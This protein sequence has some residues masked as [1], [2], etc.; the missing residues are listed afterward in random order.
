[1]TDASNVEW[2]DLFAKVRDLHQPRY[3]RDAHG[4]KV[5]TCV[6]DRQAWPCATMRA[7]CEATGLDPDTGGPAGEADPF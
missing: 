2:R 3:F 6:E 4:D 1:M 5:P 7:I